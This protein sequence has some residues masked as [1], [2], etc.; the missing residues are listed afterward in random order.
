MDR[1]IYIDTYFRIESGYDGGRMSEEKAGAFF[2]E[3]KRLSRNKGSASRRVNT[4]TTVPKC[5]SARH[6]CTVTRKNS[7]DP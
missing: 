1:P 5:I 4:K 3:V 6:A 2:A 7:P